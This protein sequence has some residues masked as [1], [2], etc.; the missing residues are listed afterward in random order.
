MNTK[1]TKLAALIAATG[2][3]LIEGSA[4]AEPNQ[5]SSV[6]ISKAKITLPIGNED[7]IAYAE[8][9]SETRANSTKDNNCRNNHCR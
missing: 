5:K 7:A 9:E 1:S 4:S 3:S 2:I 6:E 8:L